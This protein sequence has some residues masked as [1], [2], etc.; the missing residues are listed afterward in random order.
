MV[1]GVHK[2]LFIGTYGTLSE[3]MIISPILDFFAQ[4]VTRL[5]M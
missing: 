4:A 2:S 1:E 5:A 3:A